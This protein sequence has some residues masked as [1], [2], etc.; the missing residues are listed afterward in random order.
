MTFAP[1]GDGFVYLQEGPGQWRVQ[2]T[3]RA[4]V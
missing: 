3:R 4:P 2:V 1:P